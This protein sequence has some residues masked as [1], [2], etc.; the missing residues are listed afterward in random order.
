MRIVLDECI[1]ERL[2]NNFSEHICQTARY[3]GFAGMKNGALLKAAE[4]ANSDVLLTVD[5]N[6]QHQRNCGRQDSHPDS[7][8]VYEPL[9][10][11]VDHRPGGTS[12]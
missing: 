4:E 1:D 2:R 5:Q 10:R 12:I 3:A 11:F 8:G 6:I 9:E 7:L